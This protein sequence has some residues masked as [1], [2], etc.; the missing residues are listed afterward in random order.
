MFFVR[1]SRPGEQIWGH[2]SVELHHA[3]SGESGS[4]VQCRV[5]THDDGKRIVI[6]MACS[7]YV[8]VRPRNE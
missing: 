1:V 5:T 3:I 2:D 4:R 7:T 6:M 8:P